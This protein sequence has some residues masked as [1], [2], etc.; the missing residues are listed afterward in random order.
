MVGPAGFE[1]A[2][3][4]SGVRHL[5]LCPCTVI[6]TRRAGS[7]A[8]NCGTS[9]DGM[10]NSGPHLRRF[11]KFYIINFALGD[12]IAREGT[13][14]GRKLLLILPV[15]EREEQYDDHYRVEHHRADAPHRPENGWRVRVKPG[16][17][18]VEHEEGP[19]RHVG[20]SINEGLE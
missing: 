4:G 10:H 14:L 1:P 18:V 20:E 9:P 16:G 11:N 15:L 3:F 5:K 12:R 19:P 6:P 7:Q 8:H 17:A 2:A 13:Y